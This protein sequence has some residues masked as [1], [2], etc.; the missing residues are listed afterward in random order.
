MTERTADGR[1]EVTPPSTTTKTTAKE[2]PKQL[3]VARGSS[4]EVLGEYLKQQST[5]TNETITLT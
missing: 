4:F 5:R 1:E 2:P 3:Y